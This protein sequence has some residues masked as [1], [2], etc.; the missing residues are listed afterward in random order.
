M[1]RAS[2]AGGGAAWSRW[3]IALVGAMFAWVVVAAT[4]L[5]AAQTQQGTAGLQPVPALSGRVVD[6]TGTL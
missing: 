6:L 5:F 4:P 1:S 2:M 3:H